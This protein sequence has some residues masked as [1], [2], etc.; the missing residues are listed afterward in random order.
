MND[1]NLQYYHHFDEI[2]LMTPHLPQFNVLIQQI[3]SLSRASVSSY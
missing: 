2:R 3:T 1:H